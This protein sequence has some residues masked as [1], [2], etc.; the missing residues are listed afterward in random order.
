[1]FSSGESLLE[2][3]AELVTY[4]EEL[5]REKQY[6]ASNKGCFIYFLEDKK[7]MIW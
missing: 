4:E 1:M 5:E 3:S 7:K 6:E 2:Y